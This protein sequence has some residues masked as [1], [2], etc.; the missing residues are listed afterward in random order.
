MFLIKQFPSFGYSVNIFHNSAIM[1]SEIVVITLPVLKKM[2]NFSMKYKCHRISPRT[3]SLTE[4]LNKIS[5]ALTQGML[6][7][8]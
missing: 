5:Y 7:L 1:Q 3:C 6:L 4:Y 2:L 8:D